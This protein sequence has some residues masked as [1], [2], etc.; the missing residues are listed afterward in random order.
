MLKSVPFDSESFKIN[1]TI[2]L[3]TPED[4]WTKAVNQ[5]HYRR[6]V[7]SA[8]SSGKKAHVVFARISPNI[9]L[10]ANISPNIAVKIQY[11]PNEKDLTDETYRELQ[12][13]RKLKELRRFRICPGFVDI[14]DWFKTRG[15]FTKFDKNS[16]S[17]C[18][19]NLVLERA[20]ESLRNFLHKRDHVLSE[21][22]FKVIIFQIL[23]ALHCA[24]KKYQFVHN[25]LHFDN[26][27]IKYTKTVNAWNF[28]VE[29]T[30]TLS[31]SI[32]VHKS[33]LEMT[34]T[35][36]IKVN[37]KKEDFSTVYVCNEPFL[38]KLTDFGKSRISLDQDTV[39]YNP[40]LSPFFDPRIDLDKLHQELKKIKVQDESEHSGELLKDFKRK[41]N[42]VIDISQLLTH[43]YFD[44]LKATADSLRG[45][46]KKSNGR[47]RSSV[48]AKKLLIEKPLICFSLKNDEPCQNQNTSVDHD[49]SFLTKTE[50]KRRTNVGASKKWLALESDENDSRLV[51]TSYHSRQRP[52]SSAV[53][54]YGKV[55][56]PI[57]LL[58]E[59]Q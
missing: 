27:M 22:T 55:L 20:D 36:S 45:K 14:I 31:P 23:F 41:L 11:I 52:R 1:Q 8:I 26:I 13:L 12:I 32:I 59:D 49:E 3:K 29:K 21:P 51:N 42:K 44:S 57:K 15:T 34:P 58:Q 37:E 16:D 39:I 25:D 19:M 50:R 2:L 48:G 28:A 56:S 38:I 35:K 47:R 53:A 30:R 54:N 18:Y 7:F 9:L 43:E 33:N 17:S 5:K 4:E 10:E 24:Q 40:K 46:D 6:D